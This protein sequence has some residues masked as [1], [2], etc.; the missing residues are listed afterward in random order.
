ML[1]V[2]WMNQHL[3]KTSMETVILAT[4]PMMSIPKQVFESMKQGT[5]SLSMVHNGL[6]KMVMDLA[7]IRLV[8]MQTSALKSSVLRISIHLKSVVRMMVMAGQTIGAGINS[9]VTLR[10]GM[11]LMVIPTVIIGE[12]RV[13]I[14]PATYLGQGNSSREPSLL[15]NA[16]SLQRP[17]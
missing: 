10:N 14:L 17:T 6:T 15:T 7:T 1:S 13:G 4:T 9:Q 8:T 2:V 3:N 12:T 11:I 5:H 16:Q